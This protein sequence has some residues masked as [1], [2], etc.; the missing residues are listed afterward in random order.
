M[1][2]CVVTRALLCGNGVLS[3]YKGVAMRLWCFEWL[4]GRCYALMVF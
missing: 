1:M 2:F 4:L 3:G